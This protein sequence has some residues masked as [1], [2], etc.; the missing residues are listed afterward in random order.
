[1]LRQP[2]AAARGRPATWAGSATR[3]VTSLPTTLWSGITVKYEGTDTQADQRNCPWLADLQ[4]W[5]SRWRGP[6]T[7][8]DRVDRVVAGSAQR[9]AARFSRRTP[10]ARACSRWLGLP[11]RPG[12]HFVLGTGAVSVLGYYR[13]IPAIRIWN[14]L[15]AAVR[16]AL[17]TDGEMTPKTRGRTRYEWRRWKGRQR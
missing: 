14:G 11:A 5:M 6:G 8:G 10:T 15:P 17:I 3:A 12:Q 2:A 1:M 4:R 9:A 16:R 7:V 13:E